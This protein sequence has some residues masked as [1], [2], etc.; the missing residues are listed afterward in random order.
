MTTRAIR[1]RDNARMLVEHRGRRPDAD[2]SQAAWLGAHRDD[3]VR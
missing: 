2:P 1:A 3:R